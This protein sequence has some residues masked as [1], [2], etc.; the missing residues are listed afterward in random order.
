MSF[1]ELVGVTKTYG[2]GT[3]AVNAVAGLDLAVEKGDFALVVGPSGAGKTTVLNILGGME[4]PTSGAV[5]V[6]GRDI[7]RFDEA[8]LTRYRRHE[9]GFVFQFYNLVASLTARE[10]VELASE[11]CDDPLPAEE[12]LAS[13]GLSDRLDNFPA[14]LS[15]G[16]Q[17]RVAIA[18]ALAKNPRLIL[19]DEPTGALDFETGRSVLELLQHACADLGTTLVLITHNLA[20]EPIADRVVRIANGHVTEVRLNPAPAP[21]STLVW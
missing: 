1:I 21:A 19:A 4:Q 6:D 11:L 8:R 5:M 13:V 7:A 20:F 16:K 3:G 17:Q 12:V 14:E 10:N 9:V 18:R 15:G 2:A